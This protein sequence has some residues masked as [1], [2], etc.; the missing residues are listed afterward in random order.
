MLDGRWGRVR[1]S[2]WVMRESSRRGATSA[3]CALRSASMLGDSGGG[4]E[5][6]FDSG[7]LCARVWGACSPRASVCLVGL[8]VD[9]EL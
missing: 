9:P 3:A 7:R 4:V 6:G 2:F 8:S 5:H 1:H